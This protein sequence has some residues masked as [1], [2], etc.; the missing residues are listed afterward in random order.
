M[1]PR[2]AFCLAILFTLCLYRPS[3]AETALQN[4]VPFNTNLPG[5]LYGSG[6]YIDVPANAVSLTATVTNGS[7][8][9]DLYVKYGSNVQGSTVPELDADTDF[10]SD[11]PTANETILITTSSNPPL[12]AGKWYLTVLNLNSAVTSFTITATYQTSGGS[13]NEGTKHTVVVTVTPQTAL[14]GMNVSWKYEIQPGT[15]AGNI[16]VVAAVFRPDGA[17][18]FYGP[19]GLTPTPTPLRTNVPLQGAMTDY[20]LTNQRFSSG[21]MEGVYTYFVYLVRAGNMEYDSQNW[22]SVPASGTVRFAGMSSAQKAL[23][24]DMGAHRCF[25]KLSATIPP[26]SAS[27]NRGATPSTAR[28]IRSSMG[29]SWG[30]THLTGVTS[31][32]FPV[33]RARRI[34]SSTPPI[35]TYSIGMGSL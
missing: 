10:I 33:P 23:I 26:E 29:R 9:L 12:R 34:I 21:D 31:I 24:Q 25:R 3:A 18:R 11:G 5:M 6:L 13:A 7:G 30:K 4:G 28:S 32:R 2:I 19:A 20:V 15:I 27:M 16:D 35:K 14:P 1:K 22:V 8:D 17:L